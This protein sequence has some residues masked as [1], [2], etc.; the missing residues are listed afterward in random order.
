MEKKKKLTIIIIIC[1]ILFLIGTASV[2]YMLINGKKSDKTETETVEDVPGTGSEEAASFGVTVEWST[3][4][5][6]D[7]YCNATYSEN[8]TATSMEKNI[9]AVGDN[10]YP[11]A[12]GEITL[13]FGGEA[14][15]DA[16]KLVIN[17]AEEYSDNWRR[18]ENGEV[19]HPI[20]FTVT[21]NIT[22][23]V[24]DAAATE[25][26][27]TG[28]SLERDFEAGTKLSGTITIN[29]EWPWYV[30]DDNDKADSYMGGVENAI[31]NITGSASITKID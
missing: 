19:Y 20:V 16:F 7:Y 26:E 5:S 9:L 1:L 22:A 24:G 3:D 4:T 15:E 31:Y 23:Q 6:H 21:S 10:I 14:N 27:F 29:W 17:I 13:T 25:V 11:E 2:S 12:H 30:S 18:S 28:N 8:N